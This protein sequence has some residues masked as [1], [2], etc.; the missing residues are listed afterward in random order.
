MILII[1]YTLPNIRLISARNGKIMENRERIWKNMKRTVFSSYTLP[2]IALIPLPKG[3][4]NHTFHPQIHNFCIMLRITQSLHFYIR[5]L[6]LIRR[7]ELVYLLPRLVLVHQMD[8]TSLVPANR[9][10]HR[11]IHRFLNRYIR[12]F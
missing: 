4:K 3:R 7:E 1:Q 12:H 2:K 9:R 10:D 8:Y 5:C 6:Y 11:L